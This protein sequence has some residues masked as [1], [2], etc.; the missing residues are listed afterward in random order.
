MWARESVR[1]VENIDTTWFEK[2]PCQLKVLAY[3]VWMQVF[4]ELIAENDV[5]GVVRHG[6]FVSVIDDQLEIGRGR[7]VLGALVG[8]IDPDHSFD[9]AGDGGGEAAVSRGELEENG[10]RLEERLQ[11]PEL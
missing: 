10:F 11:Q 6:E 4:E 8:N 1:R 7:L 9:F 2:S 3:V 5:G